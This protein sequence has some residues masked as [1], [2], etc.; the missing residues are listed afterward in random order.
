MLP[1]GENP[2]GFMFFIRAKA[3][4]GLVSITMA[5]AVA[6]APVTAMAKSVRTI[7][8][9]E[10]FSALGSIAPENAQAELIAGAMH[11]LAQTGSDLFFSS[12]RQ[13]GLQQIT[14]K[15]NLSIKKTAF[16]VAAPNVY[17]NIHADSSLSSEIVGKMYSND[18]AKILQDEGG[19]WV[20]VESGKVIGYVLG[21]YLVEGDEAQMITEL[22]KTEVAVVGS[23]GKDPDTGSE[24]AGSTE[25]NAEDTITVYPVAESMEEIEEREENSTVKDRADEAQEKADAAA[26]VAEAAQEKAE[27]AQNAVDDS[28]TEASASEEREA[29]TAKAVAKITQKAADGAQETADAAKEEMQKSGAQSGEAVAEFALQFVGNPYVWGGSSLTNGTD[30]SGFTMAVYAH[31]GVSLPHYDASQR[32]YGIAISSLSDARAGDLICYYGH[33]GIYI[34]DGMI[35]HASNAREG[36]KVSRADYRSIAAIRRI[37]Y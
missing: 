36:I 30:C 29:E 9:A 22:V 34:G 23:G 33:V 5:A 4:T 27:E 18:V 13:N 2:G 17:L 11:S 12:A 19:D 1:R 21:D 26:E 28:S 6:G 3:L 15:T 35:V 8:R 20:K 24:D 37:F 10:K 32:N 16:A 25:E 14:G 7:R 31:F